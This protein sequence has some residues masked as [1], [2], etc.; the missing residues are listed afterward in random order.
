MASQC[1]KIEVDTVGVS[2]I[3]PERYGEGDLDMRSVPTTRAC[4]TY[5]ELLDWKMRDHDPIPSWP[6]CA[7][8][9]EEPAVV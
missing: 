2:S 5:A 3:A 8:K 7:I 1:S 6:P 4:K 9:S